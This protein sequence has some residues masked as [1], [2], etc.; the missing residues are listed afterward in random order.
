MFYVV[1]FVVT[2]RHILVSYYI[3]HDS[4]LLGKTFSMYVEASQSSWTTGYEGLIELDTAPPP[5]T[6]ATA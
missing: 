6:T 2:K 1:I 5:I 3:C 4:Y